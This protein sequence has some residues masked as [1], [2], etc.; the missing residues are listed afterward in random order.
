MIN[1][2][3]A[4][5]IEAYLLARAEWVHGDEIAGRFQV[6]EREL[7]GLD[8]QP[9]YCSHC[10][11]SLKGGYKHVAAATKAEYVEFKHTM[12][13]H[14]VNQLRRLR[15][16]DERRHHVTRTIKVGTFEKDSGQGVWP[17]LTETA[18]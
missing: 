15:D 8:G 17:V 6:R 7:R 12:K 5:Q 4:Q 13:K 9:G 11:I 3:K 1:A 2:D 16:L 18:S 10:A 14:S